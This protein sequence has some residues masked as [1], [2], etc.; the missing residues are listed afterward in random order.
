L[1]QNLNPETSQMVWPH[2]NLYVLG[3]ILFQLLTKI[4]SFLKPCYSFYENNVCQLMSAG[5]SLERLGK[6][7]LF[8]KMFC[9]SH[10][11]FLVTFSKEVTKLL[12]N[13]CLHFERQDWKDGKNRK[14][15]SATKVTKIS[16]TKR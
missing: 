16:K 2:C 1:G 4:Y 3:K 12:L 7:I 11:S 9:L 10:F 13:L 14:E 6:R 5:A 15:N 8:L